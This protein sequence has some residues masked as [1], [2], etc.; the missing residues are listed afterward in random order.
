[1]WAQP[2]RAWRTLARRIPVFTRAGALQRGWWAPWRPAGGSAQQGANADPLGTHSVPGD[3][4]ELEEAHRVL[5]VGLDEGDDPGTVWVEQVDLS[6][7]RRY[8]YRRDTLQF[9]ISPPQNGT[10]EKGRISMFPVTEEERREEEARAT[11]PAWQVFIDPASGRPFYYHTGTNESRWDNP[12]GLTITDADY[13]GGL[14]RV[15]TDRLTPAPVGKRALAAAVDVGVA[16]AAGAA[17]GTVI[18]W[19]LEFPAL[20][21]FG[22]TYSAMLYMVLRDSLLEQGT[23][24]LGKRAAGLEIVRTDGELASRYRTFSR[25]TYFLSVI[26]SAELFPL[27]QIL[28]IADAVSCTVR[29][30]RRLGDLMAG[31][32]VIAEQPDREQRLD[33][34]REF[35]LKKD[36]E[37][38]WRK[39]PNEVAES[40]EGAKRRRAAQR[41]VDA[42]EGR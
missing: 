37:T 6:T 22:A 5:E 24:S 14:L 36:A 42:A 16:L 18:W 35:W 30:R 20:G 3:G 7:G 8:Y 33:D 2:A 40:M 26:A 29:S 23:R 28:Q 31:T 13:A 19:E 39:M 1:M 34:Y 41:V 25:N 15:P 12:L 32:Q 4:A 9:R 17:A 27:L 21:A 11:E 10:V 38:D